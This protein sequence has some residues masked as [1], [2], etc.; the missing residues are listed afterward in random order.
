VAAW[1]GFPDIVK[2][3]CAYGCDINLQNKVFPVAFE[4]IKKPVSH[5]LLKEGET[6]LIIACA[7]GSVDSVRTLIENKADLDVRDRR[8]NTAL[9][10]VGQLGFSPVRLVF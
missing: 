8:G 3:F 7:R 4:S 6:A 2:L 5:V 9:H 1:H 10:W